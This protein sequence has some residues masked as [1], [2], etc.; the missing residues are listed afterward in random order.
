[1][2]SWQIRLVVYLAID[3]I[4]FAISLLRFNQKLCQV[5]FYTVKKFSGIFAKI[6]G[7]LKIQIGRK[8]FQR[9]YEYIL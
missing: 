8:F 7:Q 2:A 4:A 6:V 5:I 3:T 1:M 9:Y